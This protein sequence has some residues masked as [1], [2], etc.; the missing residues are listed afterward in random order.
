MQLQAAAVHNQTSK[1][2]RNGRVGER[3]VSAFKTPFDSEYRVCDDRDARK[4]LTQCISRYY[5]LFI[6]TIKD[7]VGDNYYAPYFAMIQSSG[8]GKTRLALQVAKE[9]FHGFY[10]CLRDLQSKCQ[11]SRTATVAD[12]MYFKDLNNDM[13]SPSAISNHFKRF[14]NLLYKC[15]QTF[16]TSSALLEAQQVGNTEANNAFWKKVLGEEFTEDSQKATTTTTSKLLFPILII[17]DEARC[18]QG[19]DDDGGDYN[20]FF[21]GLRRA[22]AESTGFLC[23]L[24]DTNAK[25]AGF[26]PTYK[27]DPSMRVCYGLKPFAPWTSTPTINLGLPLPSSVVV[28]VAS[29]DNMQVVEDVVQCDGLKS[30]RYNR[31]DILRYSRPMFTHAT[32]FDDSPNTTEQ[33]QQYVGDMRWLLLMDLAYNNL[34]ESTNSC[35]SSDMMVVL[36]GRYCIIPLDIESQEFLVADRMATLQVCTVGR[37]RMA[38]DYVAE[39]V[40]GECFAYFM[41]KH[42]N[43][44]MD[45]LSEL[46]AMKKVSLAGNTHTLYGEMI[47]AIIMTRAYD[48]K[49]SLYARHFSQP[50]MVQD[51]LSSFISV[52]GDG[53]GGSVVDVEENCNRPRKKAAKVEEVKK[54]SSSL[55]IRRS[56]SQVLAVHSY[57]QDA[58]SSCNSGGRIPTLCGLSDSARHY[59]L[60]FAALGSDSNLKG[61]GVVESGDQFSAIFI[62]VNY[63]SSAT[64]D[65]EVELLTT[66]LN[67]YAIEVLGSDRVP[68]VTMVMLAGSGENKTAPDKSWSMVS[69]SAGNVHIVLRGLASC[70]KLIS[71]ELQIRLRNSCYWDY[72]VEELD[73]YKNE[74][75]LSEEDANLV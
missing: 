14:F 45:S 70:E 35:S 55:L 48:I 2:G 3:L 44:V 74:V 9:T 61:A 69:D 68:Y 53:G 72:E 22:L 64:T 13:L 8:Y 29:N 20:N 36:A 5:H 32:L 18:L 42:F 39:P 7:E 38:V 28:V 12:S 26:A 30:Y 66:D 65:S 23:I 27:F 24:I 75:G 1:F 40:L 17:I 49:H 33:Q 19:F 25:I 73:H 59:R 71:T 31:F 10:I 4:A 51:I 11:P 63:P 67:R 52:G 34:F 37:K 6:T 47:A 50:V 43:K 46:I 56:I 57:D 54:D 58:H 21:M 60:R 41:T 62:R 15:A 16:P